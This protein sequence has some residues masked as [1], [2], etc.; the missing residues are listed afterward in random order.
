MSEFLGFAWELL[1]KVVYNVVAVVSSIL[2]LLVFG[3]VE[4]FNIF[5]TYFTTFDLVGKIGAVILFAMLIIRGYW[6][7]MHA[8]DR[9]GALL[10]AGITTHLALQTFLNIAVV[11]NFLP[12]T[13]IS[14]P[15]F[16]YGGT[17]LL[18][19]LFE[20]GLILSVSRQNDNNFLYQKSV[21]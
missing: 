13:G 20:V 4:Y 2:N 3:W 15:F 7:A 16:S 6:I 18:M 5:M 14:L 1:A 17:A 11:T 8:R 9:F 21:S 12:A 10:A 19:Q